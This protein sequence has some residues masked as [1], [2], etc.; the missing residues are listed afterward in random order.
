[1][2]DLDLIFKILILGDSGVGKSTLLQQYI[3]ECFEPNYISTVGVDYYCKTITVQDKRVKLALWDTAGQE[4]FKAITQSYLRSTH[5]IILIYD[6]TNAESYNHVKN[7]YALIPENTRCFL[8][9]NKSDLIMSR[10]ITYDQGANLAKE[11]NCPFF[12]TSAKYYHNIADTFLHIASDLTN[13]ILY[14]PYNNPLELHDDNIS[15]DSTI[16]KINCCTLL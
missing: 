1:M 2:S 5:G 12:E 8:I 4:R 16:K 7:W 13:N 11:I 10:R 15:D 14:T 3:D 9:G 6:I